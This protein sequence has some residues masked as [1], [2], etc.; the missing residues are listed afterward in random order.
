MTSESWAYLGQLLAALRRYGVDGRRIGDH[1][2]E[3]AA[4]LEESS[5][6]PVVEFGP[7][8]ELA[9][10][11][12]ADGSG[13]PVWVRSLLVRAVTMVVATFGATVAIEAFMSGD[14]TSITV[15]Q[16]GWAVGF[17]CLVAGLGHLG[18][19]RL[20]GRSFASAVTVDVIAVWAVGAVMVTVIRGSDRVLLEAARL[21]TI[22]VGV[23]LVVVGLL[24][25]RLVD[26]PVRFPDGFEYLAP[27]RRGVFAGRAPAH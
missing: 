9:M 21:P 10:R 24:A 25:A 3:M 18:T 1:V 16:L 22:T 4:H 7:P 17:A 20:D 26:S 13:L 6:D 8:A 11:L 19:R 5:G 23:T 14:P 12:A 27:L 2:A 15:G